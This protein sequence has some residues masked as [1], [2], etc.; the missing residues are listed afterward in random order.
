M[1]KTYIYIYVHWFKRLAVAV[2]LAFPGAAEFRNQT[3]NL[4][5]PRVAFLFL[6]GEVFTF[7]NK[8]V[9]VMK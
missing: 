6:F 2:A 7:V 3:E 1:T 5:N 9:L 4:F 8:V